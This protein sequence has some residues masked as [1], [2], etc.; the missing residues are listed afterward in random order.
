MDSKIRDD[1]IF[2]TVTLNNQSSCRKSKPSLR[3]VQK[4]YNQI[5]QEFLKIRREILVSSDTR[6]WM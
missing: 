6:A 1:A 5:F 4:F 2:Y 3:F